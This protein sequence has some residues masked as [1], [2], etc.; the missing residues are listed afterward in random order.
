MMN[1]AAAIARAASFLS[2]K[3]GSMYG[4]ESVPPLMASDR[5]AA[6]LTIPF[7]S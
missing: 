5:Q 4:N 6:A 3:S 2:V 7:E 1:A